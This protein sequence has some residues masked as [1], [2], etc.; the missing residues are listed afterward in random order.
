[1]VGSKSKDESVYAVL[2]DLVRIKSG[3]SFTGKLAVSKDFVF[4]K[5]PTECPACENHEF[6]GY[7]VL[8]AYDGPLIWECTHC[9]MRYPRFHI[10]EMEKLLLKVTHLWTNPNDWGYKPKDEFN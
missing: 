4:D 7:E 6:R 10:E 3:K 5:E 8:G 2:F 1:M 9:D